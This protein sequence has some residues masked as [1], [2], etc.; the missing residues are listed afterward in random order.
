M[1]GIYG[2]AEWKEIQRLL[3]CADL[4]ISTEDRVRVQQE[5]KLLDNI[6]ILCMILLRVRR[7]ICC[8]TQIQCFDMKMMT[9]MHIHISTL[10]PFAYIHSP[11]RTL[12]MID[13]LYVRCCY[14][15]YM[16]ECC[17]KPNWNKLWVCVSVEHTV[18]F[19]NDI[20]SSPN[21]LH[22]SAAAVVVVTFFSSFG[23]KMV[24]SMRWQFFI[25]RILDAIMLRIHGMSWY[26]CCYHLWTIARYLSYRYEIL[27]RA[28]QT[29]LQ[30]N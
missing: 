11:C 15:H 8:E 18:I 4:E 27:H 29:R 24:N 17:I 14:I 6:T 19:S 22:V 12:R 20:H 7:Y 25:D 2:N 3:S 1:R 9:K 28:T 5:H 23:K 21:Y 26:M 13:N 30:T 10:I 16:H